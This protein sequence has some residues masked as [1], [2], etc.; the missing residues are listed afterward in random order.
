[1]GNALDEVLGMANTKQK[2]GFFGFAT[3]NLVTREHGYVDMILA[4]V[5]PI[6]LKNYYE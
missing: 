2:Q 3:K 4:A 6:I 5:A 1:L